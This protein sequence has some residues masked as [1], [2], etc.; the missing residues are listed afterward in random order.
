[1]KTTSQHP[2]LR[3]AAFTLIELLV[4]IAVIAILASLIFPITG[5]L[6]R[7]RMLKL[8]LDRFRRPSTLTRRNSD[9]IHRTIP[10]IQS[11]TRFTTSFRARQTPE[12]RSL[13]R[14]ETVKSG[15]TAWPLS[16]F[17]DS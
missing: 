9:F 8:N 3:P 12:R 13:R 7:Q 16:E 17:L 11:S 4:V 15:A 6:K 5:A 1:M 10:R 2:Q 14:V